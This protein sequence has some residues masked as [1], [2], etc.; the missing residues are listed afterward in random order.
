LAEVRGAGD[1]A[2][3]ARRVERGKVLVPERGDRLLDP[4]SRFLEI[5][6]FHVPD[7]RPG[8]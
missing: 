7:A 4:G 1:D 3:R 8:V 6:T 2:A 5:T